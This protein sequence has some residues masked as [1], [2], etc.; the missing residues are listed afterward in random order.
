MKKIH[1]VFMCLSFSL[2]QGCAAVLVA[3]TAGA[4]TAANDNRSIGAQIDDNGIEVKA[5]TRLNEIA[6]IR[7][8]THISVVSVN[9]VVLM[10]GQV[11]TE[12]LMQQTVKAVQS[13]RGIKQFHNQ[14]TIGTPT[15]ITTRSNDT[16][17]TTKVKT[18]LIKEEKIDAN[19]IKVV[20][21]NGTVYL[22]GLI[23]KQD[24]KIAINISRNITG[25]QQV[26]TVFEYL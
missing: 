16:W 4:V 13:I 5:A 21:E 22:M 7:D 24:A 20:T 14:M 26:V 1:I 6:G 12:H 17:L 2:L 8:N 11:S 3:G 23:S 9:G 15:S 19:S 25:V 18:S 10:I